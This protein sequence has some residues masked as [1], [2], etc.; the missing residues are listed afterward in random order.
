MGHRN[1]ALQHGFDVLEQSTLISADETWSGT[2]AI[3]ETLTIGPGVTVTVAPGTVITGAA[4]KN[5]R[6][7]GTLKMIGMEAGR[8]SLVSSGG[9]FAGSR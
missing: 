1:R 4:L 6:V 3:T 9:I 5:L 2:K 7:Q 8:I